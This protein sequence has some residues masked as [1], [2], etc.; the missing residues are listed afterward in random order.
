MT[1]GRLSGVID[2]GTSAVGDPAADLV[3]AWT[4]LRGAA[5]AAFR[6]ALPDDP[7][8]W[9]RARGWALWK[10]LLTLAGGTEIDSAGIHQPSV[11]AAVLADHRRLGMPADPRGRGMPAPLARP[12]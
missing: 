3:I 6:A 2:F 10:A 1:D 7:A 11:I 5:R 4:F 12:R 8:A 9:S